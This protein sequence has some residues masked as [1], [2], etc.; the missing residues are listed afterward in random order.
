MP[1]FQLLRRGDVFLEQGQY[2]G[3]NRAATSLRLAAECF[4]KIIGD[5]FDI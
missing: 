1:R 2:L 4:V 5:V 3:R